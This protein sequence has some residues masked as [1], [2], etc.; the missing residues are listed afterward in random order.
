MPAGSPSK[1]LSS[2]STKPAPQE[3]RPPGHV[4]AITD[5][6]REMP[7]GLPAGA[8]EFVVRTGQLNLVTAEERRR[9]IGIRDAALIAR[10]TRL[11]APGRTAVGRAG[12]RR[13]APA[14]RQQARV[15]GPPACG[16]RPVNRRFGAA[17]R[18]ALLAGPLLA[19][20]DSSVA[21]VAVQPIAR[22]PRWLC[23]ASPKAPR[24]G[25]GSGEGR[26]RAGDD[27]ISGGEVERHRRQRAAAARG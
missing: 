4:Y 17:V 18:Y 1:R 7:S 16:G 6:C 14:H 21:N 2:A 24:G 5:V 25:R 11:R 10:A 20:L 19:M 23:R 12:H 13:V 8:A 26:R 22:S 9:L 15:A 27:R 3:G